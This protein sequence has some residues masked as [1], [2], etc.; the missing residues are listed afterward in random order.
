LILYVL[1]ALGVC[2]IA[3]TPQGLVGLLIWAVV[4]LPAAAIAL[5]VIARRRKRPTNR[6]G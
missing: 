6:A 1:A 2:A 5:N 4:F 3:C